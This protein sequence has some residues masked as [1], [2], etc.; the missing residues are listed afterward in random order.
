MQKEMNQQKQNYENK[1]KNAEE[2]RLALEK[3]QQE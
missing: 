3:K 1:L 2:E